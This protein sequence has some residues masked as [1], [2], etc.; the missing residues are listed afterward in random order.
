[1]GLFIR[2][3]KDK[4]SSLCKTI[5]FGGE[6]G[7]GIKSAGNI[8][9]RTLVSLGLNV[10]LYDEYPSLIRGGHNAVFVTYS[11]H[12][13]YTINKEI[14]LLVCLDRQTFDLHKQDLGPESLVIYDHEEFLIS[15]DDLKN[16][17]CE[18]I[19]TPIRQIIKRNNLPVIVRNILYIS[20]TMNILGI[21]KNI[22]EE[23]ISK[24]LSKKV[25]LLSNNIKAIELAYTSFSE[26][27]SIKKIHTNIA[28]TSRKNRYFLSGNQ[29]ICVGAIQSRLGFYAAYPM[30]PASTIFEFLIKYSKKY[31]IIV[32]QT[33]D[34]IAAINMA[35]GASFAGARSMVGTSGGGFSLMVEALGL[36]GITE[37]PIVIV[38]AQ[39]P[40]PATGLPTWTSQAD[41]LFA[42]HAGQ[43]EFPRVI[44]CPTDHQETIELTFKAFNI[45]DKFQLPVIILSDK[46]L[47][48]SYTNISIENSN[49]KI[50]RG[51]MISSRAL[52]RLEKFERYETTPNGVS[53]RSVPGQEGGIFIANSDES[54]S[55]GFS[56]ES[57]ENRI[58]KVKKRFA[59]IPHLKKELPDLNVYGDV[60]SKLCIISWG[61]TKGAVLE[62]TRRLQ[63]IGIYLKVLALNYIEPFPSEEVK[64][65]IS[66]SHDILLVE[67]NYT[68]Q[69]GQLIKL[70]TGYEL[71]NK[72][73]KYD[74]RPVFPNE[75][76]D[77][78]M[79]IIH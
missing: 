23:N 51:F 21:D 64:R 10:F 49:E 9:S 5:V 78:V 74:G 14:D 3:R 41:L 67:G 4:P 60:K 34:E 52:M 15:N 46:F 79:E 17:P 39:R 19:E 33:E 16:L 31:K 37:T 55:R 47:S 65:F 59:K 30:T 63:N 29:A 56:E 25:D 7:E 44:L 68:S 22:L 75:I 61:S 20:S 35:I 73:L 32:K 36:A 6:A 54:D 43:D 28:P 45:A 58:A 8:I 57:A 2:K 62:A 70:H 77:K 42:L 40:G 71:K 38:L 72:L 69:L 53:P 66:S 50:E 1:M 13:V 27:K 48:E 11:E 24:I 12:P 26:Y 76:V 18:V